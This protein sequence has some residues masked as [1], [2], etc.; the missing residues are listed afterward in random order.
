MAGKRLLEFDQGSFSFKSA[1]LRWWHHIR[2]VLIFLALTF[3]LSA[4]LYL[5]FSLLVSTNTEKRLRA[6]NRAYSKIFPLLEER[7]DLI[8]DVIAGLQHKDN[9]IYEQIF[10]SAAPNVDPVGSLDTFFASDTIPDTRLYSYT[11]EKADRLLDKVA[12]V[13]EAFRKIADKLVLDPQSRPPLR[14]PLPDIS[15]PQVGASVGDRYNPFY[16]TVVRHTGIDLL[17]FAGAEVFAPADGQVVESRSLAGSAG[18][19]VKL[20]HPGGYETYYSHL[21]TRYV[22]VGQNVVAGQR[23]GT[24]GMTGNAYAP[25]LHYEVY[26]NGVMA[27]PVNYFFASVTPLEYADMLYMSSNTRQSMD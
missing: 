23:I 25:H 5:A 14:L 8:T 13:D 20:R 11:E 22:S 15:Y 17:S 26:L 10:H 1:G 18:T 7:K 21:G 4:F 27:D 24:V 3:A 19:Y 6:E 2:R 9:A 12:D 16:K